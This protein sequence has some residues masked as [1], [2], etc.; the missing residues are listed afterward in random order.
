MPKE[1]D[2]YRDLLEVLNEKYPDKELLDIGEVAAFCGLCRNTVRKYI[3]F[4]E[5]TKK[6]SKT[7]LA[8]QLCI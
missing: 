1:K 7:D 4:N 3:R 6:V 5:R 8:R 2:G